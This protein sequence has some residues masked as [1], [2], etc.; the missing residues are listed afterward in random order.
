[1]GTDLERR[2]SAALASMNGRHKAAVAL[3]ALGPERAAG[4]L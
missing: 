1:M 2:P 4:I 3:V